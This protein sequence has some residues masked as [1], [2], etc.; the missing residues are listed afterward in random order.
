MAVKIAS[1]TFTRPNNTTQYSVG[2]LV[3]NSATNTAVSPMSLQVAD[4]PGGDF[5]VRRCKLTT[6]GAVVTSGDFRVHLY[7]PGTITCANGDNGAYSTDSAAKYLGAMD[8]TL[9]LDCTDGQVGFGVPNVGN[10]IS[11]G[12][13]TGQSIQALLEARG[14]YTPISG[15]VFTL[16]M[17]RYNF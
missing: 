9:S 2:D 1:A 5:S 7:S 11:S 17:E 3:A 12:L 16:A 10:E 6:S 4:Y 13:T 14:T 8:V 15:E